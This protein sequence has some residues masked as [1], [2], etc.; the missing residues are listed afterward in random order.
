MKPSYNLSVAY[1]GNFPERQT[2]YCKTTAA[3]GGGMAL[4]ISTE[5]GLS[6][7]PISQLPKKESRRLRRA[8]AKMRKVMA[9]LLSRY[10]ALSAKASERQ[11]QFAR[12]ADIGPLAPLE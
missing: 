5:S 7:I 6:T 8:M 2:Q 10:V 3:L 1:Y 9:R 12:I 4:L 11:A